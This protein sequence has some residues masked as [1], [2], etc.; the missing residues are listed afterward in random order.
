MTF[1]VHVADVYHYK[2]GWM[3]YQ[4]KSCRDKNMIIE[5]VGLNICVVVNFKLLKSTD[6]I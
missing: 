6:L 1:S 5:L 4:S 3:D 2:S